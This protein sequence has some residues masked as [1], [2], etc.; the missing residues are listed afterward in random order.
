MAGHKVTQVLDYVT[1]SWMLKDTQKF[2]RVF[3]VISIIKNTT[4]NILLKM[5]SNNWVCLSD[6]SEVW[7][8]EIW[9]MRRHDEF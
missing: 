2:Y 5:T 8:I 4:K 6:I 1:T 9:A 7:D 3:F